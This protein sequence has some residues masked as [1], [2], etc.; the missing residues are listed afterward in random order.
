M[1]TPTT[2]IP[3][4]IPV[5]LINI[6]TDRANHRPV[7]TRRASWLQTRNKGNRSSDSSNTRHWRRLPSQRKSRCRIR[8][9]DMCLWRVAPRL[10]HTLPD[11]HRLARACKWTPTEALNWL[12]NVVPR[13]FN[14]NIYDL[15]ETASNEYGD[16][17]DLAML[18]RHKQWS[19]RLTRD[20]NILSAHLK[21]F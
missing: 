9:L 1:M 15:P 2:I 14:I 20:M 4:K 11:K 13:L 18:M 19:H 3:Y 6:W 16:A 17:D 8:L 12:P 7:T 21:Q 10:T 5:R